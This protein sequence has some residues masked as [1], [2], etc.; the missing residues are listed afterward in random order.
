M[1]QVGQNGDGTFRDH[2]VN[3]KISIPTLIDQRPK[4][5]YGDS[6]TIPQ[7]M[8]P[9]NIAIYDASP[10]NNK[11]NASYSHIT[12]GYTNWILP[13]PTS[14][15]YDSSYN[16][17]SEDTSWQEEMTSNFLNLDF[18]DVD[19]KIANTLKEVVRGGVGKVTSGTTVKA[20]LK[21]YGQLAYNPNK[22]LYFNDIDMR[23]FSFQFNL[24]PMSKQEANDIRKW[25][26]N[27]AYSAAP[28]YNSSDF[29][30]NYPSMFNFKIK[31]NGTTLLELSNLAITQLNL[32]LAP[33]G[34]IT[35][36]EDGFPTALTLSIQF[37]ESIIPT[38]NNLQNITLFGNKI[39]VQG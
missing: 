7:Y 8:I 29:F 32:D 27:L 9:D 28:S 1:S 14:V 33:E 6:N 39:M 15:N 4:E 17:T 2:A 37:K 23:D 16:W 35:W 12:G 21:K 20:A 22:Q 5:Q 30:F 24:V 26:L 25:F 3:G 31:T 10:S 34:Q 19:E 38:R 36:H 13:V 11:N 18:S